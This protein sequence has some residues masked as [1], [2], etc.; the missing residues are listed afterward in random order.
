MICPMGD[1]NLDGETHCDT[2]A[3]ASEDAVRNWPLIEIDTLRTLVLMI[4]PDIITVIYV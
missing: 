4:S 2:K 1:L 3:C